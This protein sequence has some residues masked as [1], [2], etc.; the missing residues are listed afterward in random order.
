MSSNKQRVVVVGASP[1]PERYSNQAVRLLVRHGHTVV[2]VHP[3][4]SEIEG[5]PAVCTLDNIEGR[6]DTVTLYIAGNRAESLTEALLRLRPGR[7][8]FNPGTENASLQRML[9]KHGIKTENACT[10]VLLNS[11]QF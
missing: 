4:A 7:V 9:K 11:N 8:I 10:L 2:P 5:I 6:V 3:A 1:K